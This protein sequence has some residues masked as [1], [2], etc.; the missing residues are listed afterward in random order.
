[1]NKEMKEMDRIV[2]E[3]FA[4]I[5][6]ITNKEPLKGN[7]A[8]QPVDDQLNADICEATDGENDIL[9]NNSERE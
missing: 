6:T 5:D 2:N 7:E 9:R 1:M 3:F 4:V 8:S